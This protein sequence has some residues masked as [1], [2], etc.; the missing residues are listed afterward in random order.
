[1][2]GSKE[3]V[4]IVDDD[5]EFREALGDALGREFDVVLAG[6]PEEA[7]SR[8]V[9][10]VTL[11]L[12]D[13]RLQQGNSANR[14]GLSLLGLVRQMYPELPVVMMTGYG[15]IDIAVDAMRLG[16]NDFIQKARAD[17]REFSKALHNAAEGSRMRRRMAAQDEDLKRLRPWEMVGDDPK[18]QEVRRLVDIVA[19]DGYST[20]LVR[21]DTGTGKEL[22][23]H[24]V[25]SRGWRSKFPFVPVSVPVL[26]RELVES[27]LFG[28]VKGAFTDARETHVGWIEKAQGGVLF[29]DEI[30]DLPTEIQVKLL[31]FLETRTFS[32]VGSTQEIAVD[33]QIVAATNRDLGKAIKQGEFREDLYFRL[34]AMEIHLP[35]LRERPDDIILLSEHFLFRN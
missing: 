16:A 11:A 25:Y 35:P 31:R 9:E 7:E 2:I 3:K 18:I 32:R 23:A 4:L 6:T 24:A 8:L 30:G 28:H 5:P 14:D 21:G 26:K 15:D 34:K 12:L 29:L 20:V 13:V 1:M 33:I 10:G 19:Q 17:T 27:E 22:V